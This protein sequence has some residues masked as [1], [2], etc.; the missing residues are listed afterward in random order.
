MARGRDG[1]YRRENNI[2]AFR[3]RDA[4]GGWK[5]KYTGTRDRKAGLKF[6][7]D[8]LSG[9][10]QGTLPT[11][12]AEWS[13]EQARAWWLEYRKPR[14]AAGTLTA[15]SYRLKPMIRILGNI[16][17]KQIASIELDNYVSKRLAEEI[18]PWSINKEILAWSML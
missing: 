14:V 7:N 8:F 11:Q 17:L 5:E 15:E 1:L 4:A 13:L 12:M 3:Y 6:R 16:R 9:L 10:E 2:L 18:A